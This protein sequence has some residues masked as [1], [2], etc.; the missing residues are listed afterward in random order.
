MVI[1]F[2]TIYLN[3]GGKAEIYQFFYILINMLL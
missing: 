3:L 1:L 2:F